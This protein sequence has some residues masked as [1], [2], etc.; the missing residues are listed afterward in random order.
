MFNDK[1]AVES[2]TPV[3]GKAEPVFKEN[4]NYKYCQVSR[5]TEE[6]KECIDVQL[7]RV[8]CVLSIGVSTDFVTAPVCL[9]TFLS[10][11]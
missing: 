10:K 9:P 1:Q 2:I 11:S 5:Q 3:N 8:T 7:C 4:I 6:L